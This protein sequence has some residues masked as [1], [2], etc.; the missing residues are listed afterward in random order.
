MVIKK[1]GTLSSLQSKA[2]PEAA[3][4]AGT[5]FTMPDSVSHIWLAGLGALAKAQKEGPKLF[6]A[7]VAEGTRLQRGGSI[8]PVAI[9]PEVEELKNAAASVS[10]AVRKHAGENWENLENIFQDRVGKALEKL[11]AP[12][13][14][15]LAEMERTI[16][17]L[18]A[19]ISKL[20]A[21]AKP[22]ATAKPAAK[23]KTR[24]READKS[25]AEA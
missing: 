14:S 8:R 10:E 25:R 6:E 1:K 16:D 15:R 2:S 21:E 7:L 22:K 20:E 19:R 17:D 9:K 5:G 24:P 12:G 18:R 13:E 23:R 3:P 4:T 11:G